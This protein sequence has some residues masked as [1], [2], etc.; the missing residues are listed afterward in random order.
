MNIPS[1]EWLGLRSGTLLGN[2]IRKSEQDVLRLSYRDRKKAM[3]MLEKWPMNED[4]PEQ[5]WRRELQVMLMLGF[6]A[7][8]EILAECTHGVP[9][10]VEKRLL[11]A[12]GTDEDI[13]EV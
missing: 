11:E 7:E 1:L 13:M 10:W 5:E 8:M 9:G 3:K 12:V 2:S 6:K 4:G